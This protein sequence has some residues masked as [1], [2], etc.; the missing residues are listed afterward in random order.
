MKKEEFADYVENIFFNI[1]EEDRFKT[2][3]KKTLG[4]FKLVLDLIDVMSNFGD[5]SDKWKELSTY[6][7]N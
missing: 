5:L 4:G 6:L 3:T 2:I 7:I 1:D